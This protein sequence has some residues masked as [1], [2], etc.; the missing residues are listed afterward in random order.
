MR[1]CFIITGFASLLSS[2]FIHPDNAL[3]ASVM[4]GGGAILA[5]FGLLSE[6]KRYDAYQEF[7]STPEVISSD[8]MERAAVVACLRNP[9]V[10]T[11]LDI[12][13]EGKAV[14]SDMETGAKLS[15]QVDDW[16]EASKYYCST[17]GSSPHIDP[18]DI[19]V[20]ACRKCG[21]LT[22]SVSIY[23]GERNHEIL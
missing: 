10:A 3:L 11:R 6:S 22:Q 16:I 21:F 7:T 15:P 2:M 5:V 13:G 23:F 8:A 1:T 4:A 14:I 17:C 20:W 18:N 19:S 12:D 9:G